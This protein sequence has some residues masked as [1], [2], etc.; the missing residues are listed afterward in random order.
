MDVDK[1]KDILIDYIQLLTDNSDLYDNHTEELADAREL[2]ETLEDLY[3]D[4]LTRK[5]SY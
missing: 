3:C 1:L 2:L 4:K 5:A